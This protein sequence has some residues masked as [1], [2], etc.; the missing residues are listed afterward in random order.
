MPSFLTNKKIFKITPM[1]EKHLKTVLSLHYNI[2]F[3]GAKAISLAET[4]GGKKQMQKAIRVAKGGGGSEE[5]SEGYVTL[6]V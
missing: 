6:W 3:P 2:S 5:S 4:N 1:S